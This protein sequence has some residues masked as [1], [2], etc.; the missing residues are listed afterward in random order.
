MAW[1]YIGR[2]RRALRSA[3]LT[4]ARLIAWFNVARHWVQSH[5]QTWN[6]SIVRSQDKIYHE[7]DHWIHRLVAH[8]LQ[9]VFRSTRACILPTQHVEGVFPGARILNVATRI[10]HSDAKLLRDSIHHLR[11]RL[12]LSVCFG[13]FGCCQET[14]LLRIARQS[15]KER[16]KVM[17]TCWTSR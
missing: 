17:E 16:D 12:L 5:V 10:K 6:E 8:E 1:W 7:R 9:P 3:V 4:T 13:D 15:T 11:N 2:E 14:A